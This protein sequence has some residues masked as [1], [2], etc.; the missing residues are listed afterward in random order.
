MRFCGLNHLTLVASPLP[1]G[2]AEW[3]M[4]TIV[5]ACIAVALVAGI[6]VAAFFLCRSAKGK[7]VTKVRTTHIPLRLQDTLLPRRGL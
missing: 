6:G 1:Q 4:L 5:I 3:V 7:D 2:L